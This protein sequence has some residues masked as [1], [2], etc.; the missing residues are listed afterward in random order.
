MRKSSVV[1]TTVMEPAGS[2]GSEEITSSPRSV[3]L[4]RTV[5]DRSTSHPSR[6]A[7]SWSSLDKGAGMKPLGWVVLVVVL[8]FV[9]A[10]WVAWRR[11]EEIRREDPPDREC[12]GAFGPEGC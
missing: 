2:A 11:D 10:D 9:L 1:L 12:P 6:W 4:R 3:S 5:R 7:M 8:F